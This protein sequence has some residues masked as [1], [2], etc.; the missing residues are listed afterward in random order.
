MFHY[1]LGTE[2]TGQRLQFYYILFHYI[3]ICIH[4]FIDLFNNIL[5]LFLAL[6]FSEVDSG[7]LF[8]MSVY[9]IVAIHIKNYMQ[10]VISLFE[11]IMGRL[12]QEFIQ[13][14]NNSI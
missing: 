9:K 11:I 10:K 1:H 3:N 14:G 5:F 6:L 13:L 7:N 12:V 8:Y 4:Q 2:N